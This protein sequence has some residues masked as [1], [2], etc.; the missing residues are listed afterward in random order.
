MESAVTVAWHLQPLAFA[1]S[2]SLARA[3]RAL[4]AA[5]TSR[6]ALLG[7]VFPARDSR[8]WLRLELTRHLAALVEAPRPQTLR[9][10]RPGRSK[11]AHF[12]SEAEVRVVCG[13]DVGHGNNVKL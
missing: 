13:M 4:P 9:G 10:P 5:V 8:S 3:G 7:D 11:T 1:L 6:K 12:M 2:P